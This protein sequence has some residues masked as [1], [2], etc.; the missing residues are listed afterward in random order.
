MPDNMVYLDG[1]PI[2]VDL[3]TMPDDIVAVQWNGSNGQVEYINRPP[4]AIDSLEGFSKVVGMAKAELDKLLTAEAPTPEKAAAEVK[5]AI[6]QR[7]LKR[8]AEPMEGFVLDQA[9]LNMRSGCLAIGGRKP[10]PTPP[11]HTGEWLLTDGTWK[12]MT[13]RQLIDV[14]ARIEER[15]GLYWAAAKAHMDQVDRMVEAGATVEQIKQ[16]DFS[17]GL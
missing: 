6:K 16:Y 13:C 8:Q 3:S 10:I 11:P 12:K 2:A 7:K 1:R 15:N 5:V 9:L 17:E 4:E 14:V